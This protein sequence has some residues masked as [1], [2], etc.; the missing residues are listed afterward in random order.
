MN[1]NS[2]VVLQV[3]A[4]LL[5]CAIYI[6]AYIIYHSDRYECAFTNRKTCHY[7]IYIYLRKSNLVWE[8]LW[9]TSSCWYLYFYWNMYNTFLSFFLLYY[10]FLENFNAFITCTKYRFRIAIKRSLYK[11]ERYSFQLYFWKNF[12]H[13]SQLEKIFP[14]TSSK[15]LWI[16]ILCV[17]TSR[18]AKGVRASYFFVLFLSHAGLSVYIF[19]I[20]II[21]LDV[22]L[23]SRHTGK[24]AHGGISLCRFL[25]NRSLAPR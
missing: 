19:L 6:I 14:Q 18:R 16:N 3:R 24:T 21:W 20:I 5:L 9:S 10:I 7:V 4:H 2:R 13:H 17:E 11:V 25:I 23:F 15:Y 1:K 8:R 12:S 22:M